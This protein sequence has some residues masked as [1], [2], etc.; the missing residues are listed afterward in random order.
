MRRNSGMSLVTAIILL[1]ILAALGAFIVSFG[2]VQQIDSA[3]DFQGSQAYHAARSGLEYGAFRAINNASCPASTSVTLSATQQFGAFTNVTV[4][5]S[6][7]GAPGPAG[8]NE[9]GV[10]KILYALTADACNQPA[11]GGVCP[12]P[13][14][15]ANYVEREL[16]LSVIN[17]P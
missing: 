15:G 14:P 17:P 12:N 8:H 10:A 6:T 9:A 3:F 2:T 5:C 1:L 7:Q 4:S 16:Q 13:A 11:A